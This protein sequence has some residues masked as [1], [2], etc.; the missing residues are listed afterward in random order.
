M[1]RAMGVTKQGFH[2][3]LNA[4]LRND[5]QACQ[6][7]KIIR[8]IRID[9]PTM[10]CRTMYYKINPS[11]IGRDRF[12]ALCRQYGYMSNNNKSARRTTNSNG[13][14]R[15]DNL[16]IGLKLTS[17]NQLWSSDITYFEIDNTFYYITFI[18]DCFSRRI[19]G[20]QVSSRL[21]TEHTTLPA[22]KQ[23]IQ[24]R[25]HQL[26]PGIIFHSDGGGQYYD[27]A[28]LALTAKY[29]FNNSMCEFAYEN[30]KAE[31]LNGIIKNNYLKHWTINNLSQLTKQVD[32][33]VRLYNHDKP[34]LSL[35]RKTPVEFEKQF[36]ILDQQN[37][38]INM[39][40]NT[41]IVENLS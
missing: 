15:F 19:L 16:T 27:K 22:L 34:H 14:V 6:L 32:R 36:P 39:N 1:Y 4:R 37:K 5:E 10:C 18:L 33:A 11:F 30:G 23:A 8:D 41:P 38:T 7:L 21:L 26:P 35:C 31:R 2:K 29:K 13:V 40:L 25:N 12:E 3:H 17:I 24:N 20:H 9:H 28:F